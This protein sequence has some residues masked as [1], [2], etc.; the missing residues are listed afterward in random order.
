MTELHIGKVR[1]KGGLSTIHKNTP[2]DLFIVCASFEQR[3]T[4]ATECLAEDY[5]AKRGIIYY[6]SEFFPFGKTKENLRIIEGI[7]NQRCKDLS[8]IEGSLNDAH[9]QFDVLRKAILECGLGEIQ[10]V[11][12]DVTSFNREALLVLMALLR[13]NYPSA[14]IRVLYVSPSA[15]GDWLSRGFREVRNVIG[16]P[17]VQRASRPTVLLALSGFEPDRVKKLIDEHEPRLVLL[18]LGDPP[19][20]KVFL[21]RNIEEQKTLLARQDVERFE[22]PANSINGCYLKLKEVLQKYINS[23]NIILA[24]MSTKLSTLG[25]YLAVEANP[26]I[27]LTCCIPGQYNMDGYSVGED[28]LFI[29]EI[30]PI[31]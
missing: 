3:T 21:G 24:P 16:F 9:K 23:Y 2:D 20:R 11:T 30:L 29:E 31:A 7:L 27:Q 10:R 14:L 12:I 6:N 26:D 25:A 4:S 1:K 22:F 28:L 13:N 5:R 19:T 8:N 15:H 17:G 18:G